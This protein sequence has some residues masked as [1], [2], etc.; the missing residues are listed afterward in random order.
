MAT[1]KIIIDTRTIKKDLTSPIYL[2]LIH[3]R[4]TLNIKLGLYIEAKHWNPKIQ[5]VKLKHPNA[6][7][8]NITLTDKKLKAEKALLDIEEHINNKS[9]HELK[10]LIIST[11]YPHMKKAT[12]KRHSLFE[13]TNK[14][15]QELETAQKH[16]TAKTYHYDILAFKRFRKGKDIYLD[17]IDYDFLKAFEA[18]TLGRGVSQNGL[19]HYMKTL[20][21]V[22]NRA[23][24]SEALDPNCYPFRFYIIRRQ[25]TIKRAIDKSYFNKIKDLELVQ[26]TTLWHTKNYILFMFFT[27]GMN[28]RDMTLLKNENIQNDRLVYIR[29]KTKRIY[30]IKITDKAKEIL[31]YYNLRNESQPHPKGYLFPILPHNYSED[32]EKDH[33]MYN[34][35]L[36][37]MNDSCNTIGDLC[38]LKT[39]LTTY[40][41]RHSW[42]TIGKK[43]GIATNVIQEA[44]GHADLA[45]TEA[46]LDC[47]EDEIMDQA[48]EKI[49]E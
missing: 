44:L 20:R 3:L 45:T 17:E 33:K 30:N 43:L 15:I 23:I 7:R 47:F 40:V 8:W 46:Y 41:I 2:R 14:I 11:L 18:H 13:F 21:A 29:R 10:D 28:F 38:G 4:K 22:L 12:K 6:K 5:K 25:K 35:A 39:K 37:Y 1:L 49:T 27:Q 26:E 24:R 9:A 42:A 36:K 16:A 19:S 48:N 32:T 34:S 31:D